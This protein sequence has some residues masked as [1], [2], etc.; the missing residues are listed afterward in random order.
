M[1]SRMGATGVDK[2][3]I[4][5]FESGPKS[6]ERICLR[7]DTWLKVLGDIPV[8]ETNMDFLSRAAIKEWEKIQGG[9]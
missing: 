6:V 8:T 5:L 9:K 4:V 3:H 7:Y 1:Y 2:W